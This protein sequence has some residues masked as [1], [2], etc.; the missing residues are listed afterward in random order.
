MLGENDS[1]I[2]TMI[3]AQLRNCS[4]TTAASL[5][6]LLLP[7]F[8]LVRD[9]VVLVLVS[10]A[11]PLSVLFQFLVFARFL[12]LWVYQWKWFDSTEENRNCYCY[13][14]E[15]HCCCCCYYSGTDHHP[16]LRFRCSRFRSRKDRRVVA[17]FY[18][19]ES[20]IKGNDNNNA[21]VLLLSLTR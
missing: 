16:F 13:W 19:N 17:E 3:Q 12:P 2:I 20:K 7:L 11:L 1:G 10:S 21:I 18:C 9:P 14:L 8:F 5:S 4:T 6:L 15:Y